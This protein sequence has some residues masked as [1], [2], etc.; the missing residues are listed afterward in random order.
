[1]KVQNTCNDWIPDVHIPSIMCFQSIHDDC[2]GFRVLLEEKGNPSKVLRIYFR[3]IWSY[4]VE[5]NKNIDK[6]NYLIFT[7]SEF[8][9][10][11]NHES[12]EILKDD[13]LHYAIYTPNGNIDILTTTPPL[14]EWMW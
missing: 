10:W 12:A 13:L 8:L 11:F 3:A 4:R 2:E 14:A 6:T 1:M 5:N 7:N 9:E